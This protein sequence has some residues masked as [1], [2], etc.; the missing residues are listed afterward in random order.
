MKNSLSVLLFLVLI[1]SCKEEN[2]LKEQKNKSKIRNDIEFQ[3]KFNNEPKLF[4]KFWSNMNYSD[5]YRVVDTLKLKRKITQ[6]SDSLIFD[7]DGYDMLIE[8]EFINNKLKKIILIS[9]LQPLG[10]F[11]FEN[12]YSPYNLFKEKYVLQDL[13][14][15][16]KYYQKSTF[17]N[18]DFK[19]TQYVFLTNGLSEI[20]HNSLI[21]NF[22]KKY[23]YV[24]PKDGYNLNQTREACCVYKKSCN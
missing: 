17:P 18:N 5:F 15:S 2:K 14:R 12:E 21:D 11:S 7:L 13:K 10:D 23:E 8:S 19:L 20:V 22:I 3:N 1:I 6:K 16:Y 4:S 9:P 24:K